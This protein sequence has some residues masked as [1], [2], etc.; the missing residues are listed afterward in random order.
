M[1]SSQHKKKRNNKADHSFVQATALSIG[2][3]ILAFPGPGVKISL[4]V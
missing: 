3:G 1:G 4:A 2:G